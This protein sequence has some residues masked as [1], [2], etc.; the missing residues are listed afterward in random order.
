[1]DID[2]KELKKFFRMWLVA[3]RK[4]ETEALVYRQVTEVAR[5][6]SPDLIKQVE[7]AA[8][9]NPKILSLLDEK[10]A[11]YERVMVESVE[12]GVLDQALSQY[13]RDWKPE[14][15]KN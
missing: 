8:R 4:I 12:K 9:D 13:L 5:T 3:L 2:P 15:P 1:M 14:G 7:T 6:I 10:Y 11:E